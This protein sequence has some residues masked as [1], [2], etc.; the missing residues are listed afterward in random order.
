MA[1]KTTKTKTT[2]T[3]AKTATKGAA[4]KAQKTSVK[5]AA[6]KAKA[7]KTTAKTAAKPAAKKT[8][9]KTVTKAAAKTSTTKSTTKSDDNSTLAVLEISGIQLIVKPGEVYEV[10]KIDARSGDTVKLDTVM[11]TKHGD[12]VKV[13][14][15]YVKGASVELKVLAQTKGKKLKA[16][17]YKA[18]ARYRRR[19]GYRA[20]LTRV[21]VVSIIA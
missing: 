6:T 8:V 16:F 5:K 4:S 11:L 10:E 2:K 21:E 12:N 20:S 7:T 3:A 17:T 19:W 9:K 14:D 1:T 13:G 18:K 15:P